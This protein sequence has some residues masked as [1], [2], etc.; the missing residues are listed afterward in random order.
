[1]LQEAKDLQ[2]NAVTKLVNGIRENANQTVFTFK[3]P[4]GSGKTYMMADFMNRVISENENII[5]IVSAL[6]KSKLAEQN[7]EAFIRYSEDGTFQKLNPYLINSE[8]NGEGS[9]CIPSDY[10]VYVLPT[11][12]YKEK[13][14]LKSEGVFLHFLQDITPNLFNG[15]NGKQIYL[16]KDEAHRATNNIDKTTYENLDEEKSFFSKVINFTATPDKNKKQIP[17]VEITNLEAEEAKLIKKVVFG[18]EEDSLE[19]AIDKFLEVKDFYSKLISKVNPCL[20]IQ[21]SNTSKGEEEYEKI[22]KLT[23]RCKINRVQNGMAT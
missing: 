19:E 13:S 17:D 3:A 7:Y 11:D 8:S 12:L 20:I 16:I 6:S 5:F 18:S 1:M 22:I 4:T 10:N 15:G 14:K 2:N 9:L 21:I 23:I